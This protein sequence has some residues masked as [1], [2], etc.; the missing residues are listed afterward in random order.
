MFF[1]CFDLYVDVIV[2]FDGSYLA[3]LSSVRG[4]GSQFPCFTLVC[5]M[6]TVKINLI[7]LFLS[8]VN[9]IPSQHST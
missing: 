3:M 1:S 8:F 5:G 9:C 7:V 6:F 4:K 2:L